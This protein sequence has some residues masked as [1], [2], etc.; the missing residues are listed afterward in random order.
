MNDRETH[1]L[2]TPRAIRRLWVGFAVLLVLTVLPDFFV[3]QYEH[4]TIDGTFGFYAW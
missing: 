2:T 4:F 1:W 3:E